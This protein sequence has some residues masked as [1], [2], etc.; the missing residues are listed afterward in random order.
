MRRPHQCAVVVAAHDIASDRGI[1]TEIAPAVF[2]A[3]QEVVVELRTLY[4]LL[5]VFASCRLARAERPLLSAEI[6]GHIQSRTQHQAQS[7][8]YLYV[9]I[10]ISVQTVAQH[11]VELLVS[12]QIRVVG[13]ALERVALRVFI[14]AI[15]AVPRN[16]H[17]RLRPHQCI[18]YGRRSVTRLWQIVALLAVVGDLHLQR[19]PFCHFRAECGVYNLTVESRIRRYPVVAVVRERYASRRSAPVA[20]VDGYVVLV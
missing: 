18:R 8:V 19:E 2:I 10:H 4:A 15:V 3:E 13:T 17:T 9:E 14:D 6:V 7:L 5:L 11:R 1:Q 20:A 16:R 12:H